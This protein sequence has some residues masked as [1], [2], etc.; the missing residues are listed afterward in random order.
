MLEEYS[1]MN[2]LLF[3][4]IVFA[5]LWFDLSAHKKGEAVSIRNAACWSAFWVVLAG[6]FAVYIGVTHGGEQSSLFLAGYLLEKSLSIDNLFVFMAIFSAFGIADRFQH[7][8]LY[9][10]IVGAL[11]L[12]MVFIAAGSTVLKLLGPWALGAFALFVL[13]SAWKMW[14][15]STREEEEIEDYTTHWSVRMTRRFFPVHPQLSGHA[16]FVRKEGKLNATPLFLC[17]I[18]IEIADVMFAFDSVPAVLAVTREPFL[19][20]TSNIFAI[21]G[22]RS[23][24]FLLA[25]AKRSL[26]HLEKAVI[27]VLVFIGCKMLL[28]LFG[29]FHVSPNMSL[30]VI[31]TLLGG[32]ILASSLLPGEDGAGDASPSHVV[33]SVGK[34]GK[35]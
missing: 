29:L 30:T 28:D 16:F 1:T 32:G 8:V 4:G 6:A 17:L 26:R 18:V 2:V 35:R 9:F 3:A 20:Y 14:E 11:V 27:L 7:R 10:G 5:A 25:A 31:V 21:L 15:A 22:L 24:Y 34:A 19:V 23:M 33:E 13:W 12:R